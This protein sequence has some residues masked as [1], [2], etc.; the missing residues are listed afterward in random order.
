M[1]DNDRGP[2][3]KIG[4]PRRELCGACGKVLLKDAGRITLWKGR[5]ERKKG[6]WR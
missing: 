2:H 3:R 1:S 6:D 5:L 4:K